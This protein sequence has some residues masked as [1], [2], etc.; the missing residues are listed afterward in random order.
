MK[1][2]SKVIMIVI[3]GAA[4]LIG[5]IWLINE[6]RYPNVRAFNDH[7]TREFL[8]KDKKVDDGFY[9]FKSKTGQYTMWFPEEY[10]VL[11]KNR[12]DYAVNNDSY[13]SWWAVYNEEVEGKTQANYIKTEFLTSNPADESIHV[14]ALFKRRFGLSV[15]NKV[16]NSQ[17]RIYY[18]SAYIY[19]KG[20]EKR[21]IVDKKKHIPNTYLAYVADKRSNKI[22][23]ISFDSS[24]KYKS[25]DEEKKQE[26]FLKML[27]NIHFNE[28][29]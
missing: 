14:E 28:G 9:E 26:W 19:F 13:E 4:I 7:F 10:Q 6:S 17:T 2:R 24:D 29:K 27:K 18:Q 11:H 23:Q 16:E 25:S 12:E 1:K 15:P 21:V 8:N 3:T 22:V 20:T 5:A